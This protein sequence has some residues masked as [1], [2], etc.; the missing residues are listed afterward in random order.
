MNV[1]LSYILHVH[2]TKASNVIVN[3]NYNKLLSDSDDE[4]LLAMVD[5]MISAIC[6]ICRQTGRLFYYTKLS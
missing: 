4:L 2:T 1:Y 6:E 5:I 3:F